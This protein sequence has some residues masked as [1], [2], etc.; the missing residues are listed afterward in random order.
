M[1]DGVNERRPPAALG[2][3]VSPLS[4]VFAKQHILDL[5]NRFCV[6]M[7]YIAKTVSLKLHSCDR[8]LLS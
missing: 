5:Y 2:L 4:Y 8:E 1:L 3:F 7:L 6:S